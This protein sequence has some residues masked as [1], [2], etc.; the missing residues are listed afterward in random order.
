MRSSKLKIPALLAVFIVSVLVYANTLGNELVRDDKHV[1]PDNP[2]IT[3]VRYIPEILTSPVFDFSGDEGVSNQYRPLYHIYL[4][5]GYAI[6]GT[7]PLGFHLVNIIFHGLSAVFVFLTA[8]ALMAGRRREEVQKYGEEGTSE[9][10]A[11]SGFGAIATPLAAALLFAAHPVNTEA[12]GWIS[13][14]SELSFALFY[15]IS[16]YLFIKSAGKA[17][18][19]YIL[20]I[21]FFFV[22]A[23]SKETAATLPPLLFLYEILVRRE[24]FTG[25]VIRLLPFAG[26]GII[27]L[28]M[29]VLA[30]K[31][32]LPLTASHVEDLSGFQL[33][34]NVPPLLAQY[35][36]KLIYPLHLSFDYAF[37]PV[38]SLA[39]ARAIIPLLF[40][41]IL[42]AIFYLLRRSNPGVLFALLLV[43]MPLLPALY[44][45]ALGENTFTERYLYVPAMGF[46]I[47]LVLGA[48]SLKG[49]VRE[50]CATSA[51]ILKTALPL[52]A[53]SLIC[54]FSAGTVMRNFTWK[55]PFTLWQ[56]TVGK[57]PDSR[58]ARNSYGIELA[59][60]GRL[61]EAASEFRSAIEIDPEG[62]RAYNNLGVIYAKKGMIRE[63]A[64]EFEKALR[65]IPADEET[66]DNLNKALMIL[67]MRDKGGPA[68]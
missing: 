46:G 67:N 18:A 28:I 34:I 24:R 43:F 47:F 12:V 57:S 26:A 60:R 19:A 55:E 5:P 25:A 2:W 20:S 65:I 63:A 7:E 15:I 53:L 6:S 64:V 21:V 51:N 36:W 4:M 41:I 61:D 27:Y 31:G 38:Y 17:N 48:V 45:P 29:R 44:I 14:I 11:S 23:C 40:V 30:L 58:I 42:L 56:D 35:A 66:R 22:S 16:L 52:L 49:F 13:A 32:A 33:L 37:H 10:G 9:E 39:E 68:E 54:A 59:A 62:A 50:R 8:S 3:S 1:I